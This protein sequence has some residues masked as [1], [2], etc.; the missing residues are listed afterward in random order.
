MVGGSSLME[1]N[2]SGLFWLPRK[3]PRCQ[4]SDAMEKL[5]KD[6]DSGLMADA[7]TPDFD[8]FKLT[9]EQL[10]VGKL[11]RMGGWEGLVVWMRVM[12]LRTTHLP[13]E[14]RRKSQTKN[15]QRRH[16]TRL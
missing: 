10:K 8:A 13:L 16:V 3:V 11:V 9:P 2:E 4:D 1:W 7:K 12:A 14:H 5:N 6:V 15:I